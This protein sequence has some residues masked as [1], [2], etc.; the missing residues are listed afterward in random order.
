MDKNFLKI[1]NDMIFLTG[2]EKITNK[3]MFR[4]LPNG[5]TISIVADNAVPKTFSQFVVSPK[6][7]AAGNEN[8]ADFVIDNNDILHELKEQN[9]TDSY[10]VESIPG[11]YM[12]S[13]K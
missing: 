5:I 10:F 7:M 12:L 1:K 2:F 13:S 9:I 6:K 11:I 4:F 3:V 8:K